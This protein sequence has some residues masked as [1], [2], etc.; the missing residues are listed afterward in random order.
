M[1]NAD[2]EGISPT[3]QI[4]YL[5]SNK[6]LYNWR[7]FIQNKVTLNSLFDNKKW[8]RKVSKSI[9]LDIGVLPPGPVTNQ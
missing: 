9:N 1:I 5:V 2:K 6:W 3:N 8:A 4:W 7:C